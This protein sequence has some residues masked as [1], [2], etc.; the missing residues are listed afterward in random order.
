M[1]FLYYKNSFKYHSNSTLCN[2]NYKTHFFYFFICY[3]VIVHC[4]IKRKET[5][6]NF[7]KNNYLAKSNKETILEHTE[8]LINNFKILNDIYPKMNV[9]KDL[10]LLA[11]VYH[12]LGKININ[13][14]KN[15]ENL[16]FDYLGIPHGLL[17]LAFINVKN[18]LMKFDISD[19]KALIYSV[20]LHH[21]RDFSQVTKKRL[22]K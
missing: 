18:L 15:I 6:A 9:N 10:L 1:Q 16:T 12:D 17:S 14:Q 7:M 8:K 13:F 2:L 4:V 19:I 22:F 21:E 5:K 11:C 3:I 20:A